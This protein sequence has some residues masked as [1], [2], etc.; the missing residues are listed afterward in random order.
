LE[1]R[2][3]RLAPCAVVAPARST[4]NRNLHSPSLHSASLP[5]WHSPSQ[6]VD[7]RVTKLEL[8]SHT[9]MSRG[10]VKV[11]RRVL[12]SATARITS[13]W[14][15]IPSRVGHRPLPAFHPNRALSSRVP[16][17]SRLSNRTKPCKTFRTP[18]ADAYWDTGA[19]DVQEGRRARAVENPH[20][21]NG[22]SSDL[23]LAPARG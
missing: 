21:W 13:N 12:L 9:S 2:G 20:A 16:S 6:D 18:L 11:N 14:G 22:F 1:S 23:D 8:G 17:G 7:F 4:P 3:A 5:P 15:R 10:P 19:G